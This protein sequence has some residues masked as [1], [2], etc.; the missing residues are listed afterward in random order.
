MSDPSPQIGRLRETSLHAALKRWYARPGDRLEV[1]VDGYVVDLVRGATLVEFQT[2]G[3]AKIR[4][5]CDSL[6][7]AGH[8]LHLVHPVT[9][10]RWIIRQDAEGRQLSRRKSPLKNSVHAVFKELV[11][12]PHLMAHPR[13]SLEV[14]LVHEE[15]IRV[16]DGRGS[17]RR[18]G[19]SIVD[20]RLLDVVDVHLLS[21]PTDLAALLPDSLA[22]TFTTADLASTMQINRRLS[23][24]MAYCLRALGSITQVGKQG[25]AYVYRRND[26]PTEA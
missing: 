25:N 26:L 13:F 5:K 17:W 16:D 7:E 22:E 4:P 23:G 10:A 2:R 6:L 24:Q 3:F 21:G 8:T 19:W 14:L 9:A 15:E 11:Y 18:K 12:V 20:R 1:P